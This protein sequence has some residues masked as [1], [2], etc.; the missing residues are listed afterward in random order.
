MK[1]LPRTPQG[2]FT[3]ITDYPMCT[4]KPIE[5]LKLNWKLDK[6]AEPG[7]ASEGSEDW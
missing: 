1:F 4:N 6:L 5:E 7:V 3:A 2:G